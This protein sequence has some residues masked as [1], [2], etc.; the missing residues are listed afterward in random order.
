MNKKFTKLMAALALLVFMTPS[1]VGWG[2]TTE[3]ITYTF[4]DKDWKATDNDNAAANWT[5]YTSGDS[6]ESASPARGIAKSKATINGTSP[7]VVNDIT[8]VTVVASA[9]QAGPTL[10]IYKVVDNT[11][12]SIYSV[13]MTKDNNKEYTV[14]LTGVNVFSGKIKVVLASSSSYK[15]VWIKSVSV[16]HTIGGG[17]TDPSITIS[18]DE[19]QNDEVNLDWNDQDVYTADVVYNNMDTPSSDDVA[20]GVYSDESCETAFT[21]NWFIADFA[22]NS[23]ESIEYAFL[24][25]NASSDTRTVYMRVETYN[26]EETDWVPCNVIA[27]TQAAQPQVATPTFSPAAGAVASG[28][29]VSISCATE[30]ATIYYTVNNGD[31]TEYTEPIVITEATTI[32]AFAT[33]DGYS[34]SETVTANYTIAEIHTVAWALDNTPSEGVYVQGVVS[35]FWGDD[36]MDD[37]LNFRYYISDNGGTYNGELL[38]YKGKDLGNV[39]FNSVDD[40]MIGDVVTIYGDLYDYQGT[41]EFNAGNYIVSKTR[42]VHNPYNLTIPEWV[43]FEL[44]AFTGPDSEGAFDYSDDEAAHWGTVQVNDGT[45]VML[46]ISANQHYTLESL[47]VDGVDVT[48]QLDDSGEYFFMMPTH[49]VTITATAAPI[50]VT[51]KYSVNGVEGTPISVLEGSTI[52][53]DPGSNFNEEYT[54]AGWTTNATDVSQRLTGGYTLSEEETTFYAVYA[55][56]GTETL[57]ENTVVL[58]GSKF[59]STQPSSPAT[60]TSDNITYTYIG[61]KQQNIQ[62]TAQNYFTNTSAFLIGKNGK[63][64][65]NTIAFGEGITNFEIYNNKNASTNVEVG[66]CFSTESLTQY[67]SGDNTWELKLSSD[68]HQYVVPDNTIPSGAKY[69]YFKI[70]SDHNAQVQFRITYNTISSTTSYYT[71]V[72]TKEIAKDTWYFIASPLGTA[73]VNMD[74]ITDLYFYDEATH[75]WKNKEVEAN[76]EGFNFALGK[77]YL[78]AYHVEENPQ[79]QITITFAG[80]SVCTDNTKTVDV[81]YHGT[82]NPLAG[83]NLVGN[84]YPHDAYL[85]QSFYT[86]AKNAQNKWVVSAVQAGSPVA[87]CTGA[88]VQ[89]E[90]TGS[91]TFSKT[92]TVGANNGS[93]QM[94]VG[95]Q[96]MER[97]SVST[98][99][100]AI[101]SFNE[102]NELQKFYFGQS[103][104]NIY[105]PQGNKEYAIACAEGQGELPVN[106]RAN[107]DGQYTLTV[108]PEGIEMGY[109]HLIDNMTGMDVDLLQTPSYTFN[110]TTRDYES[111][112]RLVFAANNEDGPSTGSGTFAFY[113]NGNWIINNAGEATL[114]VIDLTGRILSS[115]T[116]NGSVSKTINATPGVYMLRLINGDNVNVQKIVVK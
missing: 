37:G 95:Q 68:D 38:V 107:A 115:E 41:K 69:F 66:V 26:A 54:F 5:N 16:S 40:L 87:S 30:N 74:E 72:M 42:P 52:D 112:F 10:T 57:V 24:G 105:I 110:A 35:S 6:F 63:Y 97:G 33:A 79:D 32:Q 48:S 4:T 85:G 9:N 116:V 91:I 92:Y 90:A 96:T 53:L 99:D 109:L 29:E 2:Q 25:N 46:S 50:N 44:Y 64:L 111:R 71:R 13:S 60:L 98:V 12:T 43:N 86:V 56:T 101:V 11:E 22:T 51:Y 62:S 36:I 61:A 21:G 100:N 84:P 67:V 7:V 102:G 45:Q 27:I 76:A 34:D 78:A 70:R 47:Y 17:S 108:N 81:T 55:K 15:S 93:L 23:V 19:I 89:V 39:A 83:W 8:S 20:V 75:Y 31:I 1:L 82:D 58:D 114:Q 88:M 94:T 73:P 18:G 106:F 104:A 103:D 65:Y 113:S 77:G 49:N 14:N 59:G 80:T 28:T 3:T